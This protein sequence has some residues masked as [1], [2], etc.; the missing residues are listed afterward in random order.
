MGEEKAFSFSKFADLTKKLPL[1]FLF[2]Y[3]FKDLHCGS[4]GER[5]DVI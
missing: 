5:H 1:N 2:L 3:G 4:T